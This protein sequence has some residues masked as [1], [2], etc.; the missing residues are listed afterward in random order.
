MDKKTIL[1][2]FEDELRQA[3]KNFQE[4]KCIPLE[5]FDWGL[6]LHI[7]ESRAKYCIEPNT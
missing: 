3:R 4:G 2:K 7:A 6:P 1:K 5:E